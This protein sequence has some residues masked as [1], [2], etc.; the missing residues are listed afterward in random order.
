[1]ENMTDKELDKLLGLASEPEIAIDAASRAAARAFK[2]DTS[3]NVIVL[4]PKGP[5]VAA[6]NNMRWL[7]ALPLAASLAVG[8][9]LGTLGRGNALLPESLGGGNVTEDQSVLSGIDEVEDLTE[10]DVS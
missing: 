5:L 7:S 10:E 2:E 1:M 6:N 8:I 9:Y 4:T 3:S